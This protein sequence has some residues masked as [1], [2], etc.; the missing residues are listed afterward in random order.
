[1]TMRWTLPCWNRLC[2]SSKDWSRRS[3]SSCRDKNQCLIRI[4][5]IQ[6]NWLRL[7]WDTKFDAGIVEFLDCL[8]QFIENMERGGLLSSLRDGEGSDLGQGWERPGSLGDF[9][10]EGSVTQRTGLEDW[11]KVIILKR[12]PDWDREERAVWSIDFLWY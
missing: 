4:L 6:G 12:Y 11:T 5:Q 10:R 1:M 8:Q 7:I 2:P 3:N 9:V